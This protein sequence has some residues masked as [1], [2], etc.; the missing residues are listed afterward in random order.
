MLK[1]IAGDQCQLIR[2]DLLDTVPDDA[3]D[4][5][6]ILYEIEL[7]VPIYRQSLSVMGVISFSTV[8]VG[9]REYKKF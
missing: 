5:L 9:M 8:L 4:S 6:A 1:L 2:A 3:A 7:I